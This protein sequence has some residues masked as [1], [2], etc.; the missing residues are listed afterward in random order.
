MILTKLPNTRAVMHYPAT[1][2]GEHDW[3]SYND[4]YDDDQMRE[5]ARENAQPIFDALENCRLF[6]AKN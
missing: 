1:G 6:A 4:A 2:R 3:T 5:Y